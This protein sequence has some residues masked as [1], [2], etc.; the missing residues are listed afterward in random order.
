MSTTQSVQSD[1]MNLVASQ[2]Y[3]VCHN[4]YEYDKYNQKTEVF[5]EVSFTANFRN[6]F[7]PIRDI[8]SVAIFEESGS[9]AKRNSEDLYHGIIKTKTIDIVSITES[10][11]L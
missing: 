9:L 4:V 1:K 7:G 11:I 2:S 3:D 10:V 6:Y 5:K 8:R